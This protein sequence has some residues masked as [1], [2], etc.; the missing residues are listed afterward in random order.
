VLLVGSIVIIKPV[1]V[2]S[3]VDFKLDGVVTSCDGG[4]IPVELLN[5]TTLV[6]VADSHSEEEADQTANGGGS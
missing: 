4:H 2:A 6:Q 5:L 1:L 3:F